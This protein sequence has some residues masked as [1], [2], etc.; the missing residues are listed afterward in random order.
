M[1]LTVNVV[2]KPTRPVSMVLKEIAAVLSFGSVIAKSKLVE[3]TALAAPKNRVKSRYVVNI[4][5]PFS[6]VESAT[7]RKEPSAKT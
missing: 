2:K 7:N 6:G 5:L 3:L 1:G 4:T